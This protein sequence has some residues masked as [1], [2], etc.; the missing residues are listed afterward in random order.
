M[1]FKIIILVLRCSIF[2]LALQKE[3][4]LQKNILKFG[5]SINCKYKGQLFYSVDRY[6]V[7]AKFQ[8]PNLKNISIIYKK[9]PI[10]YNNS[11]LFTSL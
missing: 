7:V 9:V 6:Y 1:K 11:L 10:N 5:Y 8:L 3:P 4:H 2:V